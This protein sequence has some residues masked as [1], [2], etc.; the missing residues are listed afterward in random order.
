MKLLTNEVAKCLDL[1]Q[2]TLERWIRQ[3][4]IPIHK[5]GSNCMF[6]RRILQK[7]AE[8]HNLSFLMP[9][10]H[11]KKQ[12][13][14]KFDKLLS[15][16]KRGGV[17]YD[18]PGNDVN[19]VLG[20]AVELLTFLSPNDKKELYKRLVE[21]EHLA[22]TGIGKGVA[23]PHPRTQL[24]D[25][26]SKPLICTCF[27][28]K[29]IEFDAL[30]GQFVFVIFILLSPSVKIYLHLL[31]KLAFCLRNDGFIKFLK[32]LPDTVLFFNK[33]AE[34]ENNFDMAGGD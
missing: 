34:F 1:Q 22:S 7:W 19:Q 6:N 9:R 26:I 21:R 29:P 18:V 24:S 32:S 28:E 20:S 8:A 2:N 33:I 25:A 27:L 14:Y 23:I 17:F 16:M 4:R 11:A 5:A 10:A 12:Q 31:S 30:D 15:V 3:G 13:K